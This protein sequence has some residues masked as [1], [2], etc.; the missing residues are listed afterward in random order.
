MNYSQ[1]RIALLTFTL[2]I[3]S[4]GFFNSLYGKFNAPYVEVPKVYSDTPIVIK[5]CIRHKPLTDK[6]DSSGGGCGGADDT[7]CDS[8][9]VALQN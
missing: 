7:M 2:G 8:I 4:V 6:K 3:A 5:V 9:P 1:I